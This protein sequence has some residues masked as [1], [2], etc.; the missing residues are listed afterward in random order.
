M[1]SLRE[2]YSVDIDSSPSPVSSSFNEI[3]GELMRILSEFD[4][5]FD[6]ELLEDIDFNIDECNEKVNELK[7]IITSKY[8]ETCKLR[9]E[10]NKMNEI[11]VKLENFSMYLKQFNI[12]RDE[13]NKLKIDLSCNDFI[14]KL[15]DTNMKL[16][17]K[18]NT[19]KKLLGVSYNLAG[20]GFFRACPICLTKECDY[21]IIPCGHTFCGD[22]VS[23]SRSP[24][25]CI[26]RTTYSAQPLKLF[27]C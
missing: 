19:L 1:T 15:H 14:E 12:E 21:A 3:K 7:K 18:T 17:L 20:L 24:N 27:Y 5:P 10:S 22:C 11:Q 2:A 4:S 16:N 13:D 8:E 6:P 25:C 9:E 26:C 23:K